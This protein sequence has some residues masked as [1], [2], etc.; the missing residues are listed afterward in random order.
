MQGEPRHVK[1]EWLWRDDSGSTHRGG[2]RDTFDRPISREFYE[3]WAQRQH[4]PRL[5]TTVSVSGCTG[6]FHWR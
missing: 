4:G 5:F 6:E 1:S 3:E 2:K